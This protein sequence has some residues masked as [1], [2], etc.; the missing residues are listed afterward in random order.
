MSFSLQSSP[1]GYVPG[2]RMS[3][4]PFAT[5]PSLRL[6]LY[7]YSIFMFFCQ[8]FSINIISTLVFVCNS[9]PTL[10][11]ISETA[12][13]FSGI[14]ATVLHFSLLWWAVRL[15]LSGQLEITC[16][17]C[18]E[19][20]IRCVSYTDIQVMISQGSSSRWLTNTTQ[21]TARRGKAINIAGGHF[22]FHQLF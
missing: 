8:L 6:Y 12:A 17:L 21:T 16:D 9:V 3:L 19:P 7:L 2:M 4:L 14:E 22:H 13:L 15:P 10:I 20:P 1:S 5:P 18:A 11:N